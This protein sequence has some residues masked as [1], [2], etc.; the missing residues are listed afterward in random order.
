MSN[1]SKI[2][3]ERMIEILNNIK[4]EHGDDNISSVINEIENELIDKKYGLV[5]EEHSEKVYE[6]LIHNIPVFREDKSKLIKLLDTNDFNFLLE[7]DNLHSLRLQEKTH[8]E[9][10]DVIY[11][12]PP[13]NRGSNDF[14]Y[15]DK[16]IEKEDGFKHSMWLS[17][18]E[19]RL[20]IARKLMS[21]D[22][23]IFI[24]IDDNEQA[25]LKML[26]D[27][28]FGESNFIGNLHWKRKK[29]PSYLHGHIAGIMEYVC[30]YAKNKAYAPKLTLSS[31]S[32]STTRVDNASNEV[33][34][35]VILKNTRTK[36][37]KDVHIIKAG[38]YENKTM[39][40]EFL[41]DVL[42]K[43]GRTMNEVRAKARFRDSPDRVKRFCKEDAIFITKNYGFRRDKL[44]EELTRKKAITDLILEWGDNQDSQ[45]EL[46]EILG[47]HGFTYPK[48]IKLI[49]NL[50]KSVSKKD[51]VIL[52][53]F[54][55]SGTTG[56]AVLE[57]N[58]E[59]EGKRNFILCTNNEGNICEE[60]TYKR[61]NKAI[62][63]YAYNGKVKDEL[64]QVKLTLTNLKKMDTHLT[65][66]SEIKE[67]LSSKFD[68]FKE[69]SKDGYYT[70]YGTKEKADKKEGIPGNL[71]YYKTDFIDKLPED[72]EDSLPAKLLDHIKEMVELENMCEIDGEENIIILSDEDLDNL[73]FKDL[74]NNVTLY[75]PS[76]VLL[77]REIE[78][79][80]REKD[81]SVVDIPD[82]YFLNELREAGEL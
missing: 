42:I 70:L 28:I 25:A 71:K 18:M 26:C 24:S 78:S 73:S 14:I 35:R 48:P 12:D 6:K 32:D 7:G 66:V 65:K 40:T 23:I 59:D 53:F 67:E 58:K 11:I 43:N 47:K 37:P 69:E 61:L 5:W 10:I 81:I 29:Q 60:I 31:P 79:I 77:S 21:N 75:V 49:K 46:K 57:L 64:Y 36:L 50:I 34:E 38:V 22:G 39:S 20:S 19:R 2:K 76:Y 16:R 63:G 9:K 68:A 55:G 41:D 51:S 15:D 33:S 62:R 13:Y 3:R 80:I 1:L 17:F 27:T 30:V 4:K 45:K 82:Y 8:K 74:R 44:E 56:H 72:A 52:D 54:A